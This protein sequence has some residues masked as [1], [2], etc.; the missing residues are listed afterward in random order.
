MARRSRKKTVNPTDRKGT[1]NFF[2]WAG[3]VTV[4]LLVLLYLLYRMS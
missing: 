1:R 3:I 2:T 4:A